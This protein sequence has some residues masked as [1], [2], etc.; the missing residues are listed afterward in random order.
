[1][2]LWARGYLS[3]VR[4]V[5]TVLRHIRYGAETV[6]NTSNKVMAAN[7]KTYVAVSQRYSS[8][9]KGTLDNDE[10]VEFLCAAVRK[11]VATLRP[12]DE[13][14]LKLS[15]YMT[16]VLPKLCRYGRVSKSYGTLAEFV[17][18]LNRYDVVADC[19]YVFLQP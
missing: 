7:W 8:E 16:S 17:L 10:P 12:G 11:I 14:S 15:T 19:A 2:E 3:N 9:L 18:F 13:T 6:Y 5:C 1:M 4:V